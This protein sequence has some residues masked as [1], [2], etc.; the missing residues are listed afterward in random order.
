M[1][2]WD[3]YVFIFMPFIVT[4]LFSVQILLSC[5][6]TNIT[7]CSDMNKTRDS[8]LLSFVGLPMKNSVPFSQN[9]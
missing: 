1:E 5:N 3:G 2:K 9:C 6:A 7:L 4:M 8:K